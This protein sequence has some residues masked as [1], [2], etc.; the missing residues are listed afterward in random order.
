MNVTLIALQQMENNKGNNKYQIL[1]ICFFI[2]SSHNGYNVMRY[3]QNL[4]S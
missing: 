3:Y 2:K 1:L 4:Y